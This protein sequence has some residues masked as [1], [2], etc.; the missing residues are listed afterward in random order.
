M[1]ELFEGTKASELTCLQCDDATR[2]VEQF[3]DLSLE[4]IDK[5]SLYDCLNQFTQL[6]LMKDS[7]KY[8]CDSCNYRQEAY[9]R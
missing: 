7:E 2:R 1:D 4:P 5:S 3:Y 8:L 9:Q 6:E